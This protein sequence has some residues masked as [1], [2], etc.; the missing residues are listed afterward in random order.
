MGFSSFADVFG[1][2][3]DG[4]HSVSAE[5]SRMLYAYIYFGCNTLSFHNIRGVGP[6]YPRLP[7]SQQWRARADP[8]IF[9]PRSIRTFGT[10]WQ[11]T[12]NSQHGIICLG[13]GDMS[14]PVSNAASMLMIPARCR[15]A[16]DCSFT[17]KDFRR[18]FRLQQP[19]QRQ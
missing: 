10:Q 3:R 18:S 15:E 1:F 13:D 4:V 8:I 9:P 2:G 17:V 12:D 16:L 5:T 14:D 7:I 11:A 19:G 6:G